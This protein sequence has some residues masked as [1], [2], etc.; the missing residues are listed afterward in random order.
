MRKLLLFGAAALVGLAVAGPTASGQSEPVTC[1]NLATFEPGQPPE[2]LEATIVGTEGNDHLVGTEGP[3]VIAGL[4]GNDKISG[5]GGDDVICGGLGNDHVSGGSGND[6]IVGDDGQSF[7]L[8]QNGGM[9]APGGNDKISG[10][11]GDDS[12]GGEGGRD[13]IRAARATTSPPARWHATSSSAAPATTSFRRP[14]P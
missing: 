6:A 10:G 9:D 11:D 2:L 7:I 13:L 12:I 8:G 14:R 1:F 4:G 5:L 3:D